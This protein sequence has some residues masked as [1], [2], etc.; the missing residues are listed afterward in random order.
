[1]SGKLSV[2]PEWSVGGLA[3]TDIFYRKFNQYHFYVE[4]ADQENLY[5]EILKKVFRDVDFAKIFPLAGKQN[6]LAHAKDAGNHN[7]KNRVYLLDKDFDDLLGLKEEIDEVFY[8]SWFC[9]ENYLMEPNALIE[10]VV[11]SHPKASRAEIQNALSLD[12]IIP[13]IAEELRQLF[14]LFLFVQAEGLGISNC[15][16]KPEAYCKQTRLWELCPDLLETYF[17]TVS[18]ACSVEGIRHP[19][20]PLELDQRLAA[21]FASN[22]PERVSGKFWLAMI[23]RFLKAKYNL[24]TITFESFVFRVAK[25]CT[26]T[27]LEDLAQKVRVRY[28]V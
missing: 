16:G 11:E 24:G 26:F 14:A 4:D 2:L 19:T 18:N 15:S 21:F 5:F 7:I 23:F 20:T 8:L 17:E 25:N 1:M 27:D 28:P 10:I 6:V 13:S 12:A 3:A 9:I 22:D